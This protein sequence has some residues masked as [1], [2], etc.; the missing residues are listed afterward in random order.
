MQPTQTLNA[1]DAEILTRPIDFRGIITLP[2]VSFLL[3]GLKHSI[4]HRGQ[5]S[6]YLRPMGAKVPSIHGESHDS[7]MAKEALA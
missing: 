2:A 4:H 6:M 1:L 7:A 3:I 5:L